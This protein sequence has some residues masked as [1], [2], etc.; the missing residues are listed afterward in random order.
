M[1]PVAWILL[2]GFMAVLV[3]ASWELPPRGSLDAPLHRVKSVAGSAGAGSYYTEHA[4]ADT[5]T[6]NIVTATLADYRSYDTLGETLVVF[7][8]G[9]ACWFILRRST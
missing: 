1:K 2:S 5:R 3:Y 7:T 9:M 4:M 8:A 6:P